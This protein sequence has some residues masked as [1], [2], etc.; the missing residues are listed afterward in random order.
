V[1]LGPDPL[2]LKLS[3][4][5]YFRKIDVAL[6]CGNGVRSSAVEEKTHGVHIA[7]CATYGVEGACLEEI[8]VRVEVMPIS[9]EVIMRVL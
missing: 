7:G 8:A 4:A 5:N 3:E 6:H 2:T 1:T 9:N